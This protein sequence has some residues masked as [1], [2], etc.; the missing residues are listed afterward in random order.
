MRF[1]SNQ[2]GDYLLRSVGLGLQCARDSIR[3]RNG[4]PEWTILCPL[5][6]LRQNQ[7]IRGYSTTWLHHYQI[8]DD[9][10]QL[11]D[12]SW[13]GV[14][15][16][17]PLCLLAE[18]VKYFIQLAGKT[19]EKFICQQQNIGIPVS[20]WGHL[21]RYDEQPVVEIFT[22]T[23]G[24]NLRLGIPIGGADKAHISTLRTMP[25]HRLKTPSLDKRS[26]FAC[27]LRS[28]SQISSKNRVPP[29]ACD[30]APVRLAVA[31]EKAPFTCPNSSLS[32]NSRGMA[33]QFNEISARFRRSL[34]A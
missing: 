14:V 24:R 5:F 25:A 15:H 7:Q 10:L 31:P 30:T 13:P 33:V 28:N 27:R 19:V 11:P 23:P 3:H 29:S 4:R 20:Q 12:I 26:N 9:A 22:K 34:S 18:T 8:V 21:Y 32:I 16:Q 1:F 6:R 17:E 2:R